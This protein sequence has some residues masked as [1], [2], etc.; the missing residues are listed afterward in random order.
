MQKSRNTA[1]ELRQL[2]SAFVHQLSP[3]CKRAAGRALFILCLA[4]SALCV[5][6]MA[7]TAGSGSIQG[8]VTDPTGAVIANAT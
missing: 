7:Q 6:A 3:T 4:F 5:T 1:P 8:V 2:M